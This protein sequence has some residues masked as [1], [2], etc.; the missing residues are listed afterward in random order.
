MLSS[1]VSRVVRSAPLHNVAARG[2]AS[3]AEELKSVLA[4]QIPGR[5]AKTKA[6]LKEHGEVK[7]GDVTISQ[8]YGGMRDIKCMVWETSLLDKDEGIRFRGR[9][10]PELQAELPATLKGGEP[11][12]EALL[13]LLLTGQCPTKAQTQALTDEFHARGALPAHVVQQINN[14]PKNMH[15][16]TQLS[17]AILALQTES[18]FAA[19]YRE[20]CPKS[21]YWEHSFEDTMTLLARLPEAA[22]R[23]YRNLYHD[24]KVAQ[25][26]SSLDYSANFNRMLGYNSQ[27][28]D[29]L[30]RMYLVIH[31]DHE[32]G[33]VSAHATH[34]VGSALSD[35]YLSLSAGMNGLA[36]PL[37]GLANQEVLRWIL[38][39][40]EHFDKKGAPVNHDTIR[41]FAWETLKAGKVIPGYGHAVLRKTDPRYTAQRIFAQK[42]MPN[43]E[44]FHIVGTI[45]EVVPDVLTQHGKTKNPWPNVDSHSGVLL[46]HYGMREYDYYTVLFGVSRA[47]GV[48]SQLFWDRALGFPLERPKSLTP[49]WIED[50]VAKQAK[51]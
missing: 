24:G 30:M 5:V 47:F 41:E 13:W 27:D 10:I 3:G 14:Y 9:T 39:I 7:L 45:F 26:N 6:F 40:K 22:A 17:S 33:N 37:H 4:A 32:G 34:L 48:L 35:P 51:K 36:G 25:H 29:E 49:E 2:F 28:F 16:M 42:Y 38:D 44:L 1:V 8:A 46:S 23:I 11:G 43:D 15:P 18:V 31:S 19:K 12:P 50:F 21:E 20:G